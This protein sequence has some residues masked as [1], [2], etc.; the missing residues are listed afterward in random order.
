MTDTF[1]KHFDSGIFKIR[2]CGTRKYK[3]NDEGDQGQD[4]ALN[5]A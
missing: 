3:N 2:N 1:S 5:I 4:V